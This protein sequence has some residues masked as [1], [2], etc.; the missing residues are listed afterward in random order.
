VD[1]K[2]TFKVATTHT[3][4][5]PWLLAAIEAFWKSLKS[6]YRN[7]RRFGNG[8]LPLGENAGNHFGYH[9]NLGELVAV[10]SDNFQNF[11]FTRGSVKHGPVRKKKRYRSV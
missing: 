1:N 2:N 5:H 4:R 10:K 3:V 8:L 9:H 7:W 11:R 6:L